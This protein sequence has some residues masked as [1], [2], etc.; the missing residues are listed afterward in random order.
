MSDIERYP[1]FIRWIKALRAS[2][3][4]TQENETSQL[5]EVVVGFKGFSERF[6]TKVVSNSLD[7]TVRVTL[8]KGPFR[9]LSN[10][11][12]F[13]TGPD[14]RTKVDF[15]LDYEFS[16]PILAMLAKTNT[17]KAVRKIMES[18]IEEADRRFGPDNSRPTLS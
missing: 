9:R 10:G 15:H 3:L 14:G 7:R 18:F 17:D 4:Q 5:G 16:N 6:S 1:E 12:K 8:V 11:W 2:G 13:S